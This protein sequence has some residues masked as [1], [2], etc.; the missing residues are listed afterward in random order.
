F[1]R[2]D[3]LGKKNQMLGVIDNLELQFQ[4][5]DQF[6]E[7]RKFIEDFFVVLYND[8]QYQNKILAAAR[9]K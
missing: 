2:R 5:P 8:E 4:D 6:K 9:V 1:I 7:A 3:F